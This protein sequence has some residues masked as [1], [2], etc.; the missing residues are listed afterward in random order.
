[1]GALFG[2]AGR[3]W[4]ALD[5]VALLLAGSVAL[6]A[7]VF[8]FNDWAG[9]SNDVSDPRRA[10][11]VFGHRG[12]S[13]RDV[14]GLAAALLIAAT[15]LLAVVGA[16]TVLIGSA[17]AALSFLYSGSSSWGK[18]RP[19]VASLIHVVGGTFHFLLGYTVGHAVDARGVA[20]GI[21]FGLVFTGGHL[22]QEVRDYDADLRNG[23]LTNAVAF[24]RRR[25]FLS[26][27]LV[28]TAAYAMLAFLASFGI[29]ARPL[30]WS[31]LLWPWHVAC[32]LRALR[33]D[34]GF[35]AARWMQR[36][37]RLLFALLGLAMLLTAPPVAELARRACEHAHGRADP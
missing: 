26:S 29:L 28:F 11:R 32:S 23:I 3:E 6:T 14:A 9:H 25:T 27:L 1:L 34:L 2:S 12:I 31:A 8:V 18:G 36:R 15:L 37:Y 20:I 33:S 35:E 13:S 4:F 16:P 17:I 7:H 19:I 21:F 22:N 30:I 24:G 10:T 5:R